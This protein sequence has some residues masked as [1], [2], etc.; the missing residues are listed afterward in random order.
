MNKYKVS[1]TNNKAVSAQK[2]SDESESY[3]KIGDQGKRK[4]VEWFV[5]SGDDE[6]DAMQYA[7]RVVTENR[8]EL[9][10]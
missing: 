10:R 8:R 9:L 5:V 1:F 2:L 6:N 7:N 4:V 3:L